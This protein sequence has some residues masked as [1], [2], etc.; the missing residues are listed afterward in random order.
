MEFIKSSK[1]FIYVILSLILGL[2]ILLIRSN[3]SLMFL[4]LILFL[5]LFSLFT[6]KINIQKLFLCVFCIF[7]LLIFLIFGPLPGP[8]S[9]GECDSYKQ[10]NETGSH[11]P[12]YFSECGCL[13]LTI[14]QKGLHGFTDTKKCLGFLSDCH[15]YVT[16]TSSEDLA[17]VK[18]KTCLDC[19][20]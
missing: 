20:N 10:I 9:F 2:Y 13:G 8:I 6:K 15:C 1:D 19:E 18:H 16:F 3:I 5:F 17:N 7:L 4:F 11:S 12:V 14:I